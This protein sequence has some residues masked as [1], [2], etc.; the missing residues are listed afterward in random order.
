MGLWSNDG[1]TRGDVEEPP[2]SAPSALISSD[3]HS[4]LYYA[5]LA[6]SGHNT[7]PWSVRL[8]HEEMWVGTERSRWLP[9]VDPTNRRSPRILLHAMG[10][11]TTSQGHRLGSSQVLINGVFG[12]CD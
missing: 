3:V 6:P 2:G 4:I 1:V 8:G 11:K 12:N 5:S 7:Q 9:K 10:C